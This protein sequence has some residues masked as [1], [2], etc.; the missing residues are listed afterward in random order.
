M[1]N[2]SQWTRQVLERHS[3][4]MRQFAGFRQARLS[5]GMRIIEA[6]NGIGLNFTILPD[7]GFDI[8]TAH[9]RGIPLT[10][11]NQGS[12]F[13]PDE[14]LHFARQFN[15][16][17]VVTC[18]LQQVGWD[19]TDD[20]TGEFRGLH[21]RANRLIASEASQTAGWEDDSTYVCTLTA[22][23]AEARLFGE[24]LELNRT[25]T[26]YLDRP[27]IRIDDV[28]TNKGDLEVPLMLLYHVNPGFPFVA[29][30]TRLATPNQ[31]VYP[32][33]DEARTGIQSWDLYRE[34]TRGYKEQ[35]FFHHLKSQDNMTAVMMY[36]ETL[37][38]A[39]EWN[40][41]Q[42]PY[43][44]QWKNTRE[45]MYVCGLEPGNC[46]PE[47]QNAARQAGRLQKLAPRQTRSFGLTIEVVD[48]TASIG[49]HLKALNHIAENGTS[50]ASAKLDSFAS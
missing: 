45:T 19:E 9:Y 4:D 46:L 39:L 21:G 43:F 24:Q 7:R 48:G 47:G 50:I 30:G 36:R 38:L 5:N 2:A 31:A 3:V 27:L 49:Q 16:G 32:R 17:L 18:G 15:G 22:T 6:Y 11:I 41:E 8:W 26:M 29:E 1:Y 25:Y 40:A 35:V 20:E 14:S 23:I 34:P 28:V 37:G 33:D 13:P 44:T 42:L 12:P 10:W